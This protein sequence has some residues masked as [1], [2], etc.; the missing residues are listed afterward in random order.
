[1]VSMLPFVP[2]VRV[3]RGLQALTSRITDN[4]KSAF[5]DATRTFQQV[6]AAKSLEQVIESKRSM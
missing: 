3:N 1:M 2:T 5:E 4:A 6:V